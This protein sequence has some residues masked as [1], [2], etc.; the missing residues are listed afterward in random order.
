MFLLKLT[1]K[2]LKL[3][4]FD[5]WFIRLPVSDNECTIVGLTLPKLSPERYKIS[6]RGNAIATWYSFVQQIQPL[7]N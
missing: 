2:D 4:L 1:I 7:H 5:S 3:Q 6:V